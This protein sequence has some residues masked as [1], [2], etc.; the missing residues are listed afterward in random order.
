MAWRFH[1]TL[2]KPIRIIIF[3]AQ[4]LYGLCRALLAIERG[5]LWMHES[6]TYVKFTQAGAELFA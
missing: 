2:Y 1:R 3:P 4:W 6:R 5:W